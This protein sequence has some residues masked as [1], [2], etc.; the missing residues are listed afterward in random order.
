MHDAD[1]KDGFLFLGNHRALDFLNTRPVDG[2]QFVELLPDFAALVR[3]FRA[4]GWLS[5]RDAGQLLRRWEGPAGQKVVRVVT[6]FRERWRDQILGWE[7]GTPVAQTA[8]E[9]LNEWLAKRPMLQR[10]REKSLEWWFRLEEPEDLLAPLAQSFADLITRVDP[11]KVRKC[12]HCVL[13]FYDVSK[14]GK[15]RWCS[16]RLCGNRAKV[17]AYAARR[18]GSR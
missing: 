7:H 14:K 3:W 10:V 6:A 8:V 18:R 4:A 16:M 17:A 9:E 1:W 11:E 12:E 5:A 15:R 13:H 2:G